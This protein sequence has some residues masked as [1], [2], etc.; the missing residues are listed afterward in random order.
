RTMRAVPPATSPRGGLARMEKPGPARMPRTRRLRRGAAGRTGARMRPRAK[1]Q[2]HRRRPSGRTTHEVARI[3]L[4]AKWAEAVPR[5]AASHFRHPQ[6]ARGD[7][8]AL[9]LARPALDRVG[10]RAEELL[11]PFPGPG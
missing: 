10:L 2:G 4:E 5:S 8:V 1:R 9:D 6:A 3:P 7:R 11:V